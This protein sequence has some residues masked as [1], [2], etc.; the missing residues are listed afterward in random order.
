MANRNSSDPQSYPTAP[1]R[2]RDQPLLQRPQPNPHH[3]PPKRP[4]QNSQIHQNRQTHL[5]RPPQNHPLPP[6]SRRLHN[7]LLRQHHLRLPLP[8]QRLPPSRL[9]QPPLLLLHH[10]RR[11]NLRPQLHR[12]HLRLRHRRQVDRHHHGPR[13]QARQPP[14]PRRETNVHP[15]RPDAGKRLDRRLPVPGR[16][17][18]VRVDG[19]AGRLLARAL[20]RKLLL[21]R[22]LHAHLRHGDDDADGIHA[23]KGVQR[24]RGQQLRAQHLLVRGRHHRAA[25]HRR[26][27]E[28]LAVHRR[29]GDCNGERRRRLG[30]E[31]VWARV[32]GEDG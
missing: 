26:H 16:A 9:L 4:A 30:D 32:E 28:R 12:L 17:D 18:L 8:P 6:L 7:S 27:R 22:R 5:P 31:E 29:G 19:G 20:N 1:L 15:R 10:P 24:R 25:A 3:L 14:R 23:Q 21:R 13:G 2:R 11:P